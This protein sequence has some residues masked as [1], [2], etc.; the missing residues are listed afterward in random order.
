MR[1]ARVSA[2]KEPI[3]QRLTEGSIRAFAGVVSVLLEL[4]SRAIPYGL[5]SSGTPAKI[6]RNLQGSGLIKHFH[7]S[8][9]GLPRHDIARRAREAVTQRGRSQ[10]NAMRHT[11]PHCDM[12]FH[13]FPARQRPRRS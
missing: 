4:Q 5:G 1:A 12:R 10:H 8:Q 9:V 7:P 11:V 13:C 3:Y 2:A 6:K